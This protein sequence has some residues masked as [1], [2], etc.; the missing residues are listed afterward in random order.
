VDGR[1]A[2]QIVWS[3]PAIRDRLHIYQ[4]WLEQNGSDHYSKKLEFLFNATAEMI[5][6][7]PEIGKLSDYENV[8]IR[9]VKQYLL[10]YK[11]L[12][13]QVYVIRIWDARQ[14]PERLEIA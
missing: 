5:S 4:F 6:K 8:G 3:E 1:M 12:G 10:F 2:K 13:D 11:P 9:V 7:F 14:N